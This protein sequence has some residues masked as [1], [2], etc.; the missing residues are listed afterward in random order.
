MFFDM[1]N[2]KPVL[3]YS[4]IILNE[5]VSLIA[6]QEIIFLIKIIKRL[7]K[8]RVFTQLIMKRNTATGAK[9]SILVLPSKLSFAFMSN[10]GVGHSHLCI[11][12]HHLLL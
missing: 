4:R 12:Q 9:V 3:N 10:H 2:N 8:G 1:K 6:Q 11:Y 5:A 7:Q